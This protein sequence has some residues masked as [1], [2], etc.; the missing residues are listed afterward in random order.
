MKSRDVKSSSQRSFLKTELGAA[1]AAGAIH[2]E[3][4]DFQR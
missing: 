4:R 2:A 1:A 3:L